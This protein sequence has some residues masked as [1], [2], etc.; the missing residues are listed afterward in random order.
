IMPFW[1]HGDKLTYGLF[2]ERRGEYYYYFYQQLLARYYLER[3]SN[4]LGEIPTFSWYQPFKYGYYPFMTT[5][6]YP[7]VQR[8]NYYYMQTEKNLDDLRFVRNY[9]DIFMN[10]LEMGQFKAYNQEVDFYNS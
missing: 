8:P 3:L 6:Y 7:F 4:G 1:E 2:K 9:E 5:N 10:Y